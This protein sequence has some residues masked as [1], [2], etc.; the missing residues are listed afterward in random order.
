MGAVMAC[1]NSSQHSTLTE[2]SKAGRKGDRLLALTSHCSMRASRLALGSRP[3]SDGSP[4]ITRT[5]STLVAESAA[6]E[7]QP[8]HQQTAIDVQLSRN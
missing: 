2:Q 1:A 7:N 8:R 4:P 6:C 3:F 5:T